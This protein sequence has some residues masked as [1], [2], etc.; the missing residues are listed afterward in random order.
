MC[1]DLEEK[2]VRSLREEVANFSVVHAQMLERS[3]MKV[4]IGISYIYSY[5][6][7][8]VILCGFVGFTF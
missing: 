8:I 2:V 6:L 5:V 7:C 4:C 1:D 3:N